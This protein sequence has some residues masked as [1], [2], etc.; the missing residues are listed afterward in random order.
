MSACHQL[1]WGNVPHAKSAQADGQ[2]K[3][4]PGQ[5]HSLPD[6]SF[7]VELVRQRNARAQGL[8]EHGLS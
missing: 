4:A 6:K 8:A 1:D 7:V 2:G 5:D 3:M